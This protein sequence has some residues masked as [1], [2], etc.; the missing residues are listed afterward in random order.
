MDNTFSVIL[1]ST[2]KRD[3]APLKKACEELK[4]T[5]HIVEN[6]ADLLKVYKNTNVISI[7]ISFD[8]H[9]DA[10][11]N[12]LRFANVAGS[13][14][15]PEDADIFIIYSTEQ[16]TPRSWPG[17][18]DPRP[19][20]SLDI[21]PYCAS[22]DKG[23]CITINRLKWLQGLLRY[24]RNSF[25]SIVNI[26]FSRE[27]SISFPT[28]AAFLL[29]AAFKDMVS[30]KIEFP[31]QGLSGSI[32]CIAQPTTETGDYCNSVFVKIYQGQGKAFR[33]LQ[34]V[35]K[36]VERYLGTDYFPPYQHP[37]RYI[38]KAYSILVTDLVIGPNNRALTLREMI[39]SK[40]AANF[41]LR[42]VRDF[43]SDVLL[44]LS[45]KWQ[46]TLKQNDSDLIDNYLK[47]FLDDNEKRLNIDSENICHKWFGKYADNIKI[48]EKLRATIP[49][50][51][52]KGSLL[53]VCHGDLHTDN[54]M[55]KS[56]GGG[57]HP[58]FI[59]F[60]RTDETHVLKDIV[61]LE[62]D[63]VIRCL[64]GIKLFSN[65]NII[66]AFLE[67]L[68]SDNMGR[69]SI[70]EWT[71]DANEILQIEKV[72]TAILELRKH[73]VYT[74]KIPLQEYRCAALLKTLEVLSYGKLPY[75]QNVRAT[76]YVTYLLEKLKA[77]S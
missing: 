65:K 34:N 9:E 75:D 5:L 70:N 43:I 51:F 12:I 29:R 58:V 13:F 59:D 4:I 41:T 3:I 71:Y 54:I 63:I 40:D 2:N 28:E 35:T 62:S 23:W 74:Y 49:S 68:T 55:V 69:Y 36:F 44:I 16:T 52:L 15:E 48:E 42:E 50:K 22:D 60:S 20:R 26:G 14:L 18:L 73:S 45:K 72:R 17:A 56:I 8:E 38:G 6:E 61:T 46:A 19:I 32:A 24:S 7:I 21:E 64:C 31:R 25:R 30:I 47:R 66:R 27:A 11:N 53:R 1:Y 33:D 57:T 39:S 76:T 37:R 77:A 10:E 67:S